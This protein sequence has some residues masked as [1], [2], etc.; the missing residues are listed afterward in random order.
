MFFLEH[1]W[2]VPLLPIASA[3]VM[4]FFGRKLSKQAVNAFCV[5]TVVLAFVFSC[6][7]VYQYTG[8]ATANH[9]APFQK[10]M[11]TRVGTIASSAT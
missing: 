4:F 6:L 1:I 3:A 11:F 9:N 7:A 10:V 2:I 8:Y 5:G